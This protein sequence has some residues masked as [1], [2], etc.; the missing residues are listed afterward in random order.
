MRPSSPDAA[1]DVMD[2]G[3]DLLAEIGHLV[4]EGDLGGEE[5]VGRVF[6]QL[7]GLQRW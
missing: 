4:D 3:A 5:G 6:D 2:V 1:G 7:G